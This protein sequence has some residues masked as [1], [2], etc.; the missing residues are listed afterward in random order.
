V[1]VALDFIVKARLT[2][3]HKLLKFLEAPGKTRLSGALFSLACRTSRLVATKKAIALFDFLPQRFP[4]ALPG[5][6]IP[7]AVNG[8]EAA[9]G[10]S[11]SLLPPRKYGETYYRWTLLIAVIL[12]APWIRTFTRAAPDPLP[13]QRLPKPSRLKSRA[14]RRKR[15]VRVELL[16]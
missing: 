1:A 8:S 13:C 12:A 4:T 9:A 7:P 16:H 10:R 15:F 3:P 6:K 5:Q 11:A 2:K 14:A